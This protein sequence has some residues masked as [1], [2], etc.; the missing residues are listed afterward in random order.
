MSLIFLFF[1]TILLSNPSPSLSQQARSFSLSDFPWRPTQNKVLVSR[2]KVFAAGF[3]PT[4]SAPNRY[5]FSIW[6]YNISGNNTIRT[7]QTKNG[8]FKFIDG[9]SLVFGSSLY[10]SN[11]NAFIKLEA[12]GVV[13]QDNGA[14]LVS[15]DFDEQNKSRRL[16]LDDDGNLRVQSFDIKT[17]EFTV[18]W[19]AVQEMCTVHGTCGDN[20]I[21]MN[22]ASNTDPTFCVCPPG[23]KNNTNVNES[24]SCVIKTPWNN[25]HGNTKFLQLDYVNFYGSDLKVHNFSV[26]QLKCLANPNC[27]GFDFKYDGK[28][29]CVLQINQLRYGYC[30][31][32]PYYFHLTVISFSKLTSS[33]TLRNIVIICTLF[34][35][36]IIFGVLF[37]WGFLKKY[38]KYRDM[39]RSFSLEFLPAGGPK[40]FTYAELQAAADNFSNSVGKGGIGDVYKG[41]LGDHRVVAVKC[42]K[43][44][45]DGDAEFWAEV[46]IIAR[47]YHLNFVRLWG[48]CAEKGQR[49]LVYEHVRNGSL[50]KYLFPVS[51]ILSLDKQEVINLR[52]TDL[53]KPILDWNIRY[54]IVLHYDIKP[55]NILLGDD[56]YMVSMS[57]ARGTRGDMALEWLKLDPI[58]PKADVYSFGMVLLEL[59]SGVGSNNIQGSL[60]HS[61]DL[62]LPRWA[63]GKVFKDMKVDDILDRQIKHCF[64]N[65]LHFDFVDRMVN[66]AIWCLQDLPEVRPSIGKVAKMLEGTVEIIEPK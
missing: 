63:F 14:T 54:I 56:F 25:N 31:P 21:C 40:W 3:K 17:H 10:W 6:Y 62:Y 15:S 58:T 39:A 49:I 41:K 43:N 9:K 18:V 65:R 29:Y 8:K 59:V 7:L 38:I 35:A 4:P 1:I 33:T 66:T 55:E 52:S 36:G 12:N 46:T 23:F 11:E 5:I 34:A 19:L 2:N 20:A 22:D 64:D 60:V 45:T 47:M 42:S 28:C 61:E 16:T 51:Q 37:F 48:F 57:M 30:F 44:V 50:D 53:L 13:T 32:F 26:C 24:N 27:L